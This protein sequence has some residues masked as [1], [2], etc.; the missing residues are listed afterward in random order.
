MANRAFANL[1]LRDFDEATR[2]ERLERLIE[3]VPVSKSRP[4]FSSLVIRAVEP[5][6]PPIAEYDLRA[7]PIASP[8]IV[9]LAREHDHPDTAFEVG[10]HIDL[11]VRDA[12]TGRWND[13]PQPVTMESYGSDYEE[14]VAAAE[15]G[16]FQIDAGFEHFFTGHAGLLGTSG[17]RVVAAEHP[18]EREFLEAMSRPENLRGYQERTRENIQRLLRWIRV[19]ESTLPVERVRLWSEGE[20]NFEARL[21]EIL[22]IR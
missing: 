11:W 18:F 6:L 21:D 12:E 3:T 5:G 8:E 19:I 14:G 16:H 20:E 7:E 13:S 15:A 2:I 10:A 9:A 4:G 17:V 1:W 22:A